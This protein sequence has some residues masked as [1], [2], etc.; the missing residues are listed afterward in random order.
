MKSEEKVTTVWLIAVLI[1]TLGMFGMLFY[2]VTT[3][4]VACYEAA[5]H[6]HNLKCERR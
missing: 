6:N 1:F 2:S 3:E 4:K 5:K